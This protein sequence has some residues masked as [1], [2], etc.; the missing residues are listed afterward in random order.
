MRGCFW[1]NTWCTLPNIST[2]SPLYRAVRI[3]IFWD[4]EGRM[5]VSVMCKMSKGNPNELK[6]AE[7][8][9]QNRR[10]LMKT[11]RSGD[12]AVTFGGREENMADVSSLIC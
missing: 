11:K 4:S 8:F 10:T 12:S 6:W 3:Y 5:S 9:S 1:L 7:N 2:H